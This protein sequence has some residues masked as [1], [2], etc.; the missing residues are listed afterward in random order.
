MGA[1]LPGRITAAARV[2]RAPQV[3]PH[4]AHADGW[5]ARLDLRR[6][7]APAVSRCRGRLVSCG[8]RIRRAVR[9]SRAEAHQ[10]A[11]IGAPRPAKLAADH[12]FRRFHRQRRTAALGCAAQ[13][14][15]LAPAA[16]PGSGDTSH[17][18]FLHTSAA[19]FRDAAPF[20]WQGFLPDAVLGSSLEGRLEFFSNQ[21]IG[22]SRGVPVVKGSLAI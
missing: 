16:P 9:R 3:D 6:S 19:S 1:A 15:R 22:T 10:P 11:R 21:N 8:R 5:T 18:S 20:S 17:P 4:H 2:E 14:S 7:N 13:C 12:A